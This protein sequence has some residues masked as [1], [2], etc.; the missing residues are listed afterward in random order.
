MSLTKMKEVIFLEG[1]DCSKCYLMKPHAQKRAEANWYE[2][3][4]FRFDDTSV[5]EF[6][7][8]SVP[9][10]ILKEDWVVNQI[11]DMDGIVNLISNQNK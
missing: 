10:L 4:V 7:I 3:Q 2:F 1:L 9:M 8:Q 6:D 11:L 5:K